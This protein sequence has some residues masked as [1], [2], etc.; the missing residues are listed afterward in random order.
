MIVSAI[1][2]SGTDGILADLRTLMAWRMHGTVVVT[3]ITAQNTLTVDNVYPV[4]MEV[5]GSQ[6]ESIAADLE[7]HATKVGLLP[8]AKTVELVVELLKSFHLATN[9][10]VDPIFR[11][12]T[13][14]N[15]ADD[16]TIQAY[17]EKLFPIAEVVT[18]NIDEASVLSGLAVHDAASMKEA[19]ERIF[20]FG[21]RQ[22]I[23]TGG[24]LEA[25][26]MDIHFDGTKHSVFDAPKIASQNNRG[27]GATFSTILAT[28]LAKKQR[29]VTGIDPAK[30]YIARA[31]VHPFK[32]GKGHGPI[33]HSVA[34]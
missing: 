18:V 22:V 15:F 24:H 21:P 12:G 8:N 4:P 3:A 29:A 32:I 28:H 13:G 9:I 6:L 20:K 7:I 19:A 27:V 23:V 14:Y 5:I 34:I 2:P 25:R 10:I 33:N 31:L 30:K 16:K 26:A 1:D 11:S 17:R